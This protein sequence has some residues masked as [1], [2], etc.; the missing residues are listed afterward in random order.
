MKE[1]NKKI[2]EIES[3]EET[4]KVMKK[5]RTGGGDNLAE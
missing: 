5:Q 3:N 4:K 2:R 1:E